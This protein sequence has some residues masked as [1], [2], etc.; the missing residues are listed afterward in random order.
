MLAELITLTPGR[1][2]EIIDSHTANE[3][4]DVICDLDVGTCWN[5]TLELLE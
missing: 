3:G 1:Q 5:S 4:I 2:N